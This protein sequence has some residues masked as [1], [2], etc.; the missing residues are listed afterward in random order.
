MPY[1]SE[2]AKGEV[3]P[4]VIP[5]AN[6]QSFPALIK[7]MSMDARAIK[8]YSLQNASRTIATEVGQVV[9][10]AVKSR[11]ARRLYVKALLA[12]SDEVAETSLENFPY[13][14]MR[15]A[16][17][18]RYEQLS[19]DWQSGLQQLG[20]LAAVPERQIPAVLAQMR[21][22]RIDPEIRKGLAQ[23]HRWHDRVAVTQYIMEL[24]GLKVSISGA[25]PAAQDFLATA[26][27]FAETFPEEKLQIAEA[28]ERFAVELPAASLLNPQAQ[29]ALKDLF[30]ADTDELT[31]RLSERLDRAQFSETTTAQVG[32]VLARIRANESLG[33]RFGRTSLQIATLA[34]PLG[35][36]WGA[37][38]AGFDSA[39][40]YILIGN[41]AARPF[42]FFNAV[43]TDK[44][45]R[46][47]LNEWFHGLQ[48][49]VTVEFLNATLSQPMLNALNEE[50]GAQVQSLQTVQDA[51]RFLNPKYAP[52]PLNL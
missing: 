51:L 13:D 30:R 44:H 2:V 22:Q 29:A 27:R 25:R 46:T 28:G 50:D 24:R 35:A 26:R 3:H 49:S 32:D 12:L 36:A 33:R 7:Y 20:S 45:L 8:N 41:I 17:R 31:R 15:D 5:L 43:T 48:K 52:L 4:E 40:M 14:S 23:D 18:M 37:H 1:S 19:S 34:A 9:R 16:I 6:F 10:E 47:K 11:M 21:G 39:L 38:S 42:H